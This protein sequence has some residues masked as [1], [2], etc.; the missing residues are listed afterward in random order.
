MKM[1]SPASESAIPQA[2]RTMIKGLLRKWAR[3]Y[4][5][6]ARADIVAIGMHDQGYGASPRCGEGALSR[7][8]APCAI[9]GLLGLQLEQGTTGEGAMRISRPNEQES[10]GADADEAGTP[11]TIPGSPLVSPGVA[12]RVSDRSIPPSTWASPARPSAVATPLLKRDRPVA[13]IHYRNDLDSFQSRL[14]R[15]IG[16]WKWRAADRRCA[17]RCGHS[18]RGASGLGVT[19]VDALR[20]RIDSRG[21]DPRSLIGS[22]EKGAD[23]NPLG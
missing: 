18:L 2:R 4:A 16:G 15:A 22:P 14:G 23:L 5:L 8:R 20:R 6:R 3:G 13:A 11:S 19:F 9:W 1:A 12:G 17:S 10:H 7:D 21:A